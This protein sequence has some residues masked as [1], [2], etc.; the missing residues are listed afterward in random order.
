MLTVERE[1]TYLL[2]PSQTQAR[3]KQKTQK[4]SKLEKEA[5]LEL[6]YKAFE[7]HQFYELKDLVNITKQPVVSCSHH[8]EFS[9]KMRNDL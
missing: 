8:R 2:S 1:I 6:L 5:V 4:S 3:E 7:K 9:M